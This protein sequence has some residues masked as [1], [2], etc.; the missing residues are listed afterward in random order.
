MNPQCWR[1]EGHRGSGM[2]PF[3]TALVS[4]YRPSIVTFP[5]SFRVSE[6]LP[7]LCSSTLLFSTPPLVSPNFLHVPLEIGAWSW[8]TKSEGVGLLFVQL[9]SKISNLCDQCSQSTNITRQTDG[10]THR[11]MTCDGK[12]SLCTIVHRVVK[13]INDN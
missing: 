5:L 10:C 4:S 12:S 3:E 11:R 6:I 7:L 8:P 1:T 13:K 2:V 9:V